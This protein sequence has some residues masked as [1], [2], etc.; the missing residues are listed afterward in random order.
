[1]RKDLKELVKNFSASKT[2]TQTIN[3]IINELNFQIESRKAPEDSKEWKQFVIDVLDAIPENNDDIY[4]HLIHKCID[5]S[6][7][8]FTDSSNNEGNKS[9]YFIVLEKCLDKKFKLDDSTKN[10][11]LR[12]TIKTTLL[13]SSL[14]LLV[15]NLLCDNESADL[16]CK[17]VE[18][19][20]EIEEE[21]PDK[22]YYAGKKFFEIISK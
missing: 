3:D 14:N 8:Y 2:N 4:N 19:I 13:E 21:N 6:R 15:D 20:M 7:T 11:F 18:T 22:A 12:D 5:H 10:E 16:F 9:F 17:Y 1:M